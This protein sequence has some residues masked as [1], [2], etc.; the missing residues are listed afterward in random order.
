MAYDI[1][2]KDKLFSIL[3]SKNIKTDLTNVIQA[4]F[5]DTFAAVKAGNITT[6]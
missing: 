3:G 2:D 6:E 4:F 1:V 5:N